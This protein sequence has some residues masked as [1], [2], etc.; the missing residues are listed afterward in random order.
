MARF[1]TTPEACEL[2][3]WASPKTLHAWLVRLPASVR[4][5]LVLRRGR[6]LLLDAERLERYLRTGATDDAKSVRRIA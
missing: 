1:L 3:R 2:Y 6:T 4:Q 5:A